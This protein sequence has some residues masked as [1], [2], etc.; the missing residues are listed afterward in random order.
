MK[1]FALFLN[2]GYHAQINSVTSKMFYFMVIPRYFN[3]R[4]SS[5]SNVLSE[6]K[7]KMIVVN[8]K[9]EFRKSKRGFITARGEYVYQK[10]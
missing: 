6:S 2:V 10:S 9:F 3:R 7:K 5:E 4:K 8:L 1:H